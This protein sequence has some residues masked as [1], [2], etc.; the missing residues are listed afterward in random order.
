[1]KPAVRPHDFACKPAHAGY[2]VLTW[3][4]YRPAPTACPS[5]P[6][7]CIAAIRRLGH[8]SV[9]VVGDVMLDRYVYGEVERISPEAPV[10]ILT[11]SASWRCR[12]APATWC[13]T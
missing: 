8:T 11:S 7:T 13:A 4:A 5:R 9:L 12:A 2:G 10:P 1:M 6:P 3:T